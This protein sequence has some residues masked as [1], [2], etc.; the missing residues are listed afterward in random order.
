[1]NLRLAILLAPMSLGVQLRGSDSETQHVSGR[2]LALSDWLDVREYGIRG[3]MSLR[4]GYAGPTAA[5][6]L[7]CGMLTVGCL[8]VW[9]WRAGV[10]VCVVGGL[11]RLG[12]LSAHAQLPVD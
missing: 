7:C 9:V 6:L 10:G 8:A 2:Q 1:M 3:Q 11:Y 5:A 12:L 4:Y